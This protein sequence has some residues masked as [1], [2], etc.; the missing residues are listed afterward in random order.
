MSK[1]KK[2]AATSGISTKGTKYFGWD[3]VP[4]G[5]LVRAKTAGTNDHEFFIKTSETHF[6]GFIPGGDDDDGFISGLDY[7]PDNWTNGVYKAMH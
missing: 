1:T 5:V 3:N 4:E 6:Q 2:D 7:K